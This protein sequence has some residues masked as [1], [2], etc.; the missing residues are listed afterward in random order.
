MLLNRQETGAREAITALAAAIPFALVLCFSFSSVGSVGALLRRPPHRQVA[1]QAMKA[2]TCRERAGVGDV[3]FQGEP[4]EAMAEWT[5][6]QR[7]AFDAQ[8]D[9]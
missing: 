8:L 3:A 5:A 2:M 6:D 9:D 1:T 7:Q 4:L